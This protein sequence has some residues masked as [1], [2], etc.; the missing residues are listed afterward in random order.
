MNRSEITEQQITELMQA[1]PR[2]EEVDALRA[3]VERQARH[4]EALQSK[5]DIEKSC[6]CSYDAPGD[7]CAAHSPALTAA[8]AEIERLR[9]VVMEGG[10]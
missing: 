10:R 6:A 4:I 1:I 7:I 2:A 9:A 8:R 5:I 3:E